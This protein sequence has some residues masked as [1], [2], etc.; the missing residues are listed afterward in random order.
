MFWVCINDSRP[1]AINCQYRG[2][3]SGSFDLRRPNTPVRQDLEQVTAWRKM[4]AI[5]LYQRCGPHRTNQLYLNTRSGSFELRLHPVRCSNSK[6]TETV[7][8]NLGCCFSQLG[9]GIHQLLLF[10][11]NSAVVVERG[12]IR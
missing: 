4:W 5:A 12:E 10:A 2:N 7:G 8:K 3:R 9:P 6:N 11:N 1:Q